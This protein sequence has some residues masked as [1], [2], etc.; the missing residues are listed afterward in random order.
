MGGNASAHQWA[1]FILENREAI[2]SVLTTKQMEE[3]DKFAYF[4]N[5]LENLNENLVLQMDILFICNEFSIHFLVSAFFFHS[6]LSN[7]AIY[8]K[9]LLF[10]L[11]FRYI[12]FVSSIRFSTK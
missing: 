3:N 8:K 12:I 4:Q 10:T 5:K 7:S 9:N 11:C 6:S 2:M 1:N